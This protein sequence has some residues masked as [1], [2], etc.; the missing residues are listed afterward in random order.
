M[1]VI[2][3]IKAILRR[4][5][6]GFSSSFRQKQF[7]QVGTCSII[8]K[9]IEVSNPS[10][11]YISDHVSLGGGCILYATN[12][13][14]TIERYF[15]SAN[16]FKVSTGEHERRIGRFLSSI[17]ETEKDYNKGLDKEVIIKEDVWAGFNVIVL[18]GT[19]IGRGCTIA[20]GSVVVKSLPPYS[21][22]GG[23]PAKFIK[24]YWDMNQIIEHEKLLYEESERYTK[25][26]L[27]EIFNKYLNC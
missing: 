18:S 22:C 1:K 10:N 11:I 5:L 13:R 21:I 4:F 17:T 23:V 14:I 20:A 6:W 3:R 9:D 8:P 19:V 24:F 16:G 25:S 2:L 12:A 26:E 7:G 15:V 27:K